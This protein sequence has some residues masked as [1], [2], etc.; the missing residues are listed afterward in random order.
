MKLFLLSVFVVI[1]S[2]CA[3]SQMSRAILVV[4]A[5][6]DDETTIGPIMAKL[7]KSDK[8][9]YIVATDGRYGTRTKLSSPDSLIA[10]RKS[11]CAC[12]KKALGLDSLIMLDYHDGLGSQT[13]VPEYFSQTRALRDALKNHIEA[14]SPTMIITFGPDG[15]TG[16]ADHRI[17][18]NLVTEVL[19]REGWVDKYPLYYLGWTKQ[20]AAKFDVDELGYADSKYFNTSIPFDKEDENKYFASIQ[21]FVSQYTKQEMASWIEKETADK[22]NVIHFR[23]FA[24]SS[25]HSSS[26]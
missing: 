17:V 20:Q 2:T 9:V 3:D 14:I 1:L 22:E 8:L 15:D 24:V 19:L 6:P 26:F 5:H 10:V 4:F 13:S 18:G 23:R 16:H 12:S 21:C 25:G 11:E 7:A